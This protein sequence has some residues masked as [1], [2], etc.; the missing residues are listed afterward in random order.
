MFLR[1][2]TVHVFAISGLHVG[3]A[4][5]LLLSALRSAGVSR[6]RAGFY[7]VPLLTIYTVITGL[8]ASA[9]RALVMAVTYWTAP[10][11]GRRPDARSALAAAAIVLLGFRPGQLAEPGFVYSFVIVAGLLALGDRLARLAG[12]RPRADPAAAEPRG[13]RAAL[14]RVGRGAAGLAAGS[15]AAWIASAPLTAL[16]ANLVSPVALVANPLAVPAAF[17]VVLCGALSLA[18]G[19]VAPWFSEV[20]N[21]AARVFIAALS[22][23]LGALDR[24][25]GGHFFVAAP[26]AAWVAWWYA[27]WA[28]V[29]L[30][31]GRRRLAVPAAAAAVAAAAWWAGWHDDRVRVEVF[32]DTAPPAVFVDLPG[33]GD[34]LVDPGPPHRSE[35][36]LRRLR[37]RGVDRLAAIVLTCADAD[38]AAATT[39]LAERLPVG[40]LWTGP[41]RGR[42]TVYRRVCDGAAAAGVPVRPWRSGERARLPGGVAWDV[43]HPAGA[44]AP[45]AES[46]R[47]VFRV[48][49][50]GWA[51]LFAGRGAPGL[52]AG[53]DAAACDTAAPVLLLERG[54]ASA[55][56]SDAALLGRVRPRWVLIQ[57]DPRVGAEVQGAGRPAGWGRAHP[58][59]LGGEVSAVVDF[60]RRGRPGSGGVRRIT[61]ADGPVP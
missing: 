33:S 47:L 29:L 53:L 6:T 30:L 27:S 5:M 48:A 49:R 24:V 11:L 52:A 44:K 15:T 42:S 23:A 19:A 51:V 55:A 36:L 32:A 20:F 58:V 37:A 9:V 14:G 56:A 54:Y 22:A 38:H 7:L 61:S 18:F 34:L 16:F 13:A 3:L 46:G 50:D 60:G 59:V 25:P 43:L 26:P 31:R 35:A 1:T 41:G 17:L 12:G 21:H 10:L 28:G 4:A 40:A 39:R 45:D 2:G 8:A 57:P